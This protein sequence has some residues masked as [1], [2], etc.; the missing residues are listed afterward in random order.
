MK[1]FTKV[2]GIKKLIF[3]P[4]ANSMKKMSLSAISLLMMLMLFS[5]K[6]VAQTTIFSENMGTPTAN[7]VIAT[8]ATGTAPATF[9]NKGTL[10]YGIGGQTTSDV[11]NTSNSSGYSGA[12]GNGNVYF[13]ATVASYGFSIETINASSYTG[14]VLSYGYRK[15]SASLH[16]AFSVDYWDGS[17]WVTVANTAGNLFNESAGAGAGWYLAKSLSL[18]AGAQISG[19]KIRFVKSGS[20]AIRLDDVKLTGIIS[21]APTV[22]TTTASAITNTTVTSGGNITSIGS[23][24]VSARGVA[25]D[26]NP[27]PTTAGTATN[28]GSG[29]T[30]TFTSTLSPLLI[31]TQYFYRAYATNSVNTSYGAESSFYTLANTP[32]TPVVNN[33]TTTSMD[34]T[35]SAN[36]NPAATQF[37]IQ[38]T[39]SGNYVQSGGTLGASAVWQTA[40]VWGTKTV[41]SLAINSNQTFQVKARNGSNVETAF[42]S[43]ASLYTLANV[44]A[45]PTV[46]NATAS[47]LDVSVNAN[48]NPVSTV[49]AIQE[50]GSSNYVQADGSLAGSAIWQTETAWA[51]T[52]VTGLS[53]TTSY[54]FHVK[55]RNGDAVETAFGASANGTTISASSPVLSATSITSFGSVCINTTAGSNSF[56]ISGTNLSTADVTVGSLSGF[57]FSTDDI[58]YTSS[59]SIPQGG[60][61]F[62][63]LIY[64]KFTPTSEITYDDNL[65]I[66]GGGAAGITAAVSGSGINTAPTVTAGA[67]NT[68]TSSAAVI[69]GTVTLTGCSAISA[70]G[71]EYSTTALFVNGTGAPVTGSN[72]SGG[73]FS[74][75]LSGL[76]TGTT[77]YFHTYAT[78]NGGTAYS[79]EDNFTTLTPTLN[80]SALADF[81]SVCTGITT[82]ANTFSITGSNLTTANVTVAAL[83]GFSYS[84]DDISYTTSLNISQSGGAFSQLIYVKFSP[85]LVQS[86]NG[87][88]VVA[89]GG[90]VNVN[91]PVSATGIN[92]PVAVTTGSAASITQITAVAAGSYIAGCSAITAYGIEYSTTIGFING[93]G[94]TEISTNQSA[95][96]FS[97]SLSSLSPGT[98][99]YFKAFATDNSGTVYGSEESFVTASLDAPNAI[100]ATNITSVSFT[101]IWETVTNASGYRLDVSSS[102]TFTNSNATD[103]F[104]SEYLEGS[105]NNKY[106]E[107]YNGTG[108]T[109]DLSNYKLQLFTNG[110][111]TVSNEV[112]LSGTLVNGATIVYRNSSSTIYGGTTI[113]NAAMNFNGNDA[114]ALYKISTSSFVDIFGSIGN[115]PGSAWTN[116]TFSTLDK[117]LVRKSIVSGGL[118]TNP[119]SSFPT[120][121]TEWIQSNIDVVSNLGSHT[122][123][124]SNPSFIAGYNNLAVADTSQSVTGLT[125]GTT[126]YYRVRATSTNNT[127]ANSNTIT[128]TTCVNVPVSVTIVANTGSAICAGTAVTFTAT[129]INGGG[130]PTYQWYNGALPISGETA[131]TYSSSALVGGD[132]ISVQLTS[133]ETCTSGNP[134]TSNNIVMTINPAIP[135]SV[136]IAANPGNTI[137]PGTSVTF[138]ATPTNG[139]SS[140]IYQWYNGAAAIIGETSSTYAS[141]TLVTGDAISVLLTSD[142]NPCATNNP[143]TSNVITMTVY[144]LPT[145]PG[146]ISGPID[147]CPLIGLVTP[148]TYSI[149][150]VA[151]AASYEWTVPVGTTLVSGQGTT[152]IDVT[153]DNS[154]ALTNSQFK[155]RTV[156]A[157]GCKSAAS[158][159]IVSKIIPG[160]PVAISGPTNVCPFI[161]QATNATYS[162]AAVQYATSYNWVVPTGVTIVSGQGTTSID[163]N[164]TVGFTSGSI[165]VTALA[166]C[167]SRSARSLTIS[168][169]QPTAPVAITGPS[170]ACQYIGNSSLV[171]Y[172]IAAVANADSYT[173]TV[174]ANVNLVSGQGTASIMVTFNTG[175]VTALFKVKSVSNCFTS[176]DRTLSVTATTYAAP[177][178]ISGP[179]SACSYIGNATQATYTIRKVSGA[180]SYQWTVPTGITIESHPGGSG[181][182]DTSIVVT[183]NNNFVNNS[184]IAVQTTGCYTSAATTLTIS[185]VT[186]TSTPGLVTGPTNACE[187]MVSAANPSGLAATYTIRKINN[188]SSYAWTA[189]NNATITAHPG[190]TGVNDTIVEVNYNSDFVNGTLTVASSNGCGFSNTRSLAVSKLK[191]GAPGGIDII[192]TE[193]CPAR[194]YSYSLAA[195]PSHA[196]SILWTVPLDGTIV[197]GQGTKT[198]TVSYL[199]TAVSGTVTATAYNNCSNSATRTIIVKIP[200]CPPPEFTRGVTIEGIQNILS[201]SLNA[202][203]SPNPSTT[204]FNLTVVTAGKEKATVRILDLQ[205]RQ[206]QQFVVMPYAS[207]KFGNNL[208]AGTYFVEVIQAKQKTIKRVMKF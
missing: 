114:I 196:T 44:P 85:T 106:I 194:Q 67:A 20:T 6:S 57:S 164:F 167:G 24:S 168:K 195:L 144:T 80:V 33:A 90:A 191:P 117:T 185:R 184:S 113:V 129:P 157:E 135:V 31:N 183:F 53:A 153:F 4:F 111:S 17:A 97:A 71:I 182:N 12:S 19:L 173:W 72:L 46:N 170:D 66:G 178:A 102:P 54:T 148:T 82:A 28:E 145:T 162:I 88:I 132:D 52:T 68:I 60:G 91:S 198:I 142:V 131:D 179:T 192:Q 100:A 30:G 87:N 75:G 74:V 59:L 121:G 159:L 38:E 122:F 143:A 186:A 108:A 7:T 84:L 50:T 139:G 136:S 125:A 177:G 207:V 126:Y 181:V 206:L 189:P 45:A 188:A 43:S 41:T 48:S 89:G 3:L 133:S 18:P 9:Q 51:T 42:G 92:S 83:S 70:Y 62:S 8:Y 200:A 94:I 49:F 105:S 137:C 205:G 150:A 156:S 172:S 118:T 193:T 11:R 93:T 174:P 163:V 10:T 154:F 152:S 171:E 201:N 119:A 25:Y 146:V 103:L 40:A 204:D 120:L 140:P 155:V 130:S 29:V 1:V 86:Y 26:T 128:V 187:Y 81:G 96:S 109:V 69:P 115:N 55:A 65:S 32:G 56:T 58:S 158:A 176:G 151:G 149:N 21:S 161:G 175:Y 107:I 76:N 37:S 23:S 134:A 141:S 61:I 127:S 169:S 199:S 116:G 138:T 124:V 202:N 98:T 99:Y 73:N 63:Q 27:I 166:N 165:K 64:V 78:N 79:A 2:Q 190:G 35:L 180:P 147:A 123:S 16:A 104:F 47:T 15:E 39:I 160:I 34:V 95:G 77:Y 14:L 203:I 13:T 112:T 101:A 22:A 36:S 208:K 5:G 110:S 197:S